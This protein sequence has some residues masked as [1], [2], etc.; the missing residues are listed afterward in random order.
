[1]SYNAAVLN[2]PEY[3]ET[4]YEIKKKLYR[5]ILNPEYT[6]DTYN[7]AFASFLGVWCLSYGFITRKNLGNFKV[8]GRTIP[9]FHAM[10]NYISSFIVASIF[11]DFLLR[12]TLYAMYLDDEE[13][14]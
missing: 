6:R 12:R 7:F 5:N 14:K 8:M 4:N 9:Q 10:G 11:H 1:M 3:L 2:D 13:S